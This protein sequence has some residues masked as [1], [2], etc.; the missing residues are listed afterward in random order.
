VTRGRVTAILYSRLAT[1]HWSLAI[2]LTIHLHL[3]SFTSTF[4]TIFLEIPYVY[5]WGRTHAYLPLHYNRSFSK[6]RVSVTGLLVDEFYPFFA[7]AT[8]W[9]EQLRI[10][11]RKWDLEASLLQSTKRWPHHHSIEPWWLRSR[12]QDQLVHK[13]RHRQWRRWLSPVQDHTIGPRQWQ[14]PHIIDPDEFKT[15]TI[16][17][18]GCNWPPDTW[19]VAT[20]PLNASIHR[21]NLESSESNW[22]TRRVTDI[23]DDDH[24]YKHSYKSI[25]CDHQPKHLQWTEWPYTW[26]RRYG[27]PKAKSR[28]D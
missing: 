17:S 26:R 6:Q 23:E 13:A 18:I 19:E 4:A 8:P 22:H 12:D 25:D 2:I 24:E 11:P 16:T 14:Q 5:L 15:T 7:H 1:S 3:Q 28:D 10:L 21:R 9:S 27:N 20:T